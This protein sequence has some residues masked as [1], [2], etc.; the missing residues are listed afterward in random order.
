M[1]QEH[2]EQF[3]CLAPGGGCGRPGSLPNL[4]LSQGALGTASRPSWGAGHTDSVRV[5]TVVVYP[6]LFSCMKVQPRSS[7][8]LCTFTLKKKWFP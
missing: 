8:N 5:K 7:V 3:T 4:Q 6:N 1:S 2:P